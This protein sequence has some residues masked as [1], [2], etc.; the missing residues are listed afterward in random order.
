MKDLKYSPTLMLEDILLNL[1]ETDPNPIKTR[2]S[3][4]RLLNHLKKETSFPDVKRAITLVYT[5]IE[6][7]EQE[8]RCP[9]CHSSAMRHAKEE[10]YKCFDCGRIGGL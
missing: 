5:A 9:V 2:N 3:V 4:I 8:M 1:L 6:V 10:S 7:R